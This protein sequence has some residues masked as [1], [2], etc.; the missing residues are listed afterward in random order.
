[1]ELDSTVPGNL[2]TISFHEVQFT[3]QIELDDV[4]RLQEA[5]EN[6]SW[7]GQL[8]MNRMLSGGPESNPVSFQFGQLDGLTSV[9]AGFWHKGG[10]CASFTLIKTER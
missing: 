6:A 1:M 4:M 5:C 8:V 2:Y 7:F 10:K 9:W 3:A